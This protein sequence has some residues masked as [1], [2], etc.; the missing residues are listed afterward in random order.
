MSS[1]NAPASQQ[2]AGPDQ[3]D[4]PSRSDPAMRRNSS[5]ASSQPQRRNS[6][7][8]KTGS[9]RPRSM[10][11]VGGFGLSRNNSLLGRSSISSNAASSRRGSGEIGVALPQSF[12]EY[13]AAS[14]RLPTPFNP[15]KLNSLQLAAFDGDVNKIRSL[16]LEKKRDLD[17][18]D[19][20]HKVTALHI[21]AE[22][23]DLQVCKTLITGI[24]MG[25]GEIKRASLDARNKDGRTALILAAIF[26]KSDIV[27]L[28]V[29]DQT[30]VDIMD[31]IGCG[32]LHYALLNDDRISFK[33]LCQAGAN[34]RIMD[35]TKNT[36]LHHAVRLGNEELAKYMLEAGADVNS[37]NADLRT[38][39]HLAAQSGNAGMVQLLLQHNADLTVPD[40]MGLKP[41]DL[42]DPDIYQPMDIST[43]EKPRKDE[44]KP[45]AEKKEKEARDEEAVPSKMAETP[46]LAQETR[47]ASKHAPD[48]VQSEL[49]ESL[50]LDTELLDAL[51]D[52]DSP[53]ISDF[54]DDKIFEESESSL[55]PRVKTETEPE[56]LETADRA[57]LESIDIP[58]KQ[59]ALPMASKAQRQ[60]LPAMSV[61]IDAPDSPT[62]K[63]AHKLDPGEMT[64]TANRLLVDLKMIEQKYA[65]QDEI[66]SVVSVLVN[67]VRETNEI[68][69][70]ADEDS[71]NYRLLWKTV[72]SEMD[73]LPP[74]PFADEGASPDK[75]EVVAFVQKLRKRRNTD[76]TMAG[77]PTS[78]MVMNLRKSSAGPQSPRQR[79]ETKHAQ[80][81]YEVKA[82]EEWMENA[83]QPLPDEDITTPE[84]PEQAAERKVLEQET[85]GLEAKRSA[86]LTEFAALKGQ[87]SHISGKPIEGDANALARS[88]AAEQMINLQLTEELDALKADHE[89]LA[90]SKSTLEKRLDRLQD[91]FVKFNEELTGLL[92]MESRLDDGLTQDDVADLALETLEGDDLRHEALKVREMS[93]RLK[94]DCDILRT[95][96][97]VTETAYA[98]LEFKAQEMSVPI[99]AGTESQETESQRNAIV[100]LQTKVKQLQADNER[101]IE[102]LASQRESLNTEV[103][104]AYLQLTESER[105][106][107][108]REDEYMRQQEQNAAD[109]RLLSEQL[110]AAME[111]SWLEQ[112]E[113]ERVVTE[114][115]GVQSSLE[116]VQEDLKRANEKI[117]EQSEAADLQGQ[118]L[119]AGV[120]QIERLNSE[121]QQATAK[122]DKETKLREQ[123][124]HEL[125]ELKSAL[126]AV[127]SQLVV[128]QTRQQHDATL[129]QKLSEQDTTLEQ[130]RAETSAELERLTGEVET[131]R[132]KLN[133]ETQLRQQSADALEKLK[134]EY[135]IACS[136]LKAAQ[137]REQHSAEEHA[138]LLAAKEQE[139][140]KALS[141]LE[142]KL[143]E[144]TRQ[145]QLAIDALDKLEF[146]FQNAQTSA[147]EA[148]YRETEQYAEE[149]GA[150]EEQLLQVREESQAELHRVKNELQ[151][152]IEK[153]E[154]ETR[155]RQ[156]SAETLEQLRVEHAKV[157]NELTEA[158]SRVKRQ[159]DISSELTQKLNDLTV[160]FNESS[161]TLEEHATAR[162]E[163]FSEQTKLL[164]Q[165]E[166]MKSERNH[167]QAEL[168]NATSQLKHM[169]SQMAETAQE[170]DKLAARC[171]HLE[172]SLETLN[173][174]VEAKR[175]TIDSL[176]NETAELRNTLQALTAKSQEEGTASASVVQYYDTEMR[177]LAAQIATE[178]ELRVARDEEHVRISQTV[179]ELEASLAQAASEHTAWTLAA[180]DAEAAL[181][182]RL[183]H[184]TDLLGG[185]ETDV[186][187]RSKVIDALERE[188]AEL[189]ATLE[190]AKAA[191]IKANTELQNQSAEY[192]ETIKNLEAGKL[193]AL[194]ALEQER[195][196]L[197]QTVTALTDQTAKHQQAID[198]LGEEKLHLLK[199]LEQERVSLGDSA[200]QLQEQVSSLQQAAHMS[201]EERARQI[202]ALERER[203]AQLKEISALREQV[204]KHQQTSQELAAAKSALEEERQAQ[205]QLITSLKEQS[206]KHAKQVQEAEEQK[207]KAHDTLKALEAERYRQQQT[208][209]NLK[210]ETEKRETTIHELEQA[211]ETSQSK[212]KQLEKKHT[213]LQAAYDELRGEHG[214]RTTDAGQLQIRL[215]EA[216]SKRDKAETDLAAAAD[217]I[218]GL[219]TKIER[220]DARAVKTGEEIKEHLARIDSLEKEIAVKHAAY[221]KADA[222]LQAAQSTAEK[223]TE[224]L[225]V[226]KARC[227]K[228][229]MELREARA[230]LTIFETRANAAETEIKQLEQA[231]LA[232]ERMEADLESG[233]LTQKEVEKR[234]QVAENALNHSRAQLQTVSREKA[235]LEDEVAK[236]QEEVPK[237]RGRVEAAEAKVSKS[238]AEAETYKLRLHEIT[239]EKT[240]LET[241]LTST[242]A[243]A[244]ELELKI[245][246]REN[247]RKVLDVNLSQLTAQVQA[248]QANT[249]KLHEVALAAEGKAHTL[250]LETGR[251]QN[252]LQNSIVEKDKLELSCKALR[253]S[254]TQAQLQIGSLR[255]ES[256][257]MSAL[258]EN[259]ILE[260]ERMSNEIQRLN[261]ERIALEQKL[262]TVLAKQ[263]DLQAQHRQAVTEKTATRADLDELR[264]AY[265]QLQEKVQAAE[266]EIEM[267]KKDQKRLSAILEAA[268]DENREQAEQ[269]ATLQ[270]GAARL[271][272]ALESARVESGESRGALETKLY[273][274]ERAVDAMQRER[275]ILKEE[276]DRLKS[277]LEMRITESQNDNAKRTIVGLEIQSL[278]DQIAE[279]QSKLEAREVEIADMQGKLKDRTAALST[280][281]KE[282]E[283]EIEALSTTMH[284]QAAQNATLLQA[285]QTESEETLRRLRD[286]ITDVNTKLSSR[287]AEIRELGEKLAELEREKRQFLH[288]TGEITRQLEAA[289]ERAQG[290]NSA[291]QSAEQVA[292]ERRQRIETLAME[293]SRR[294][295]EIHEL[296]QT[297]ETQKQDHAAETCELRSQLATVTRTRE[298]LSTRV[299]E[300][301]EN[302]EKAQMALTE[303]THSSN[304]DR[305]ELERQ[306][307]VAR[308]TASSSEIDCARMTEELRLLR[309]ALEKAHT[310]LGQLTSSEIQ[311][312]LDKQEL[313]EH[314][315]RKDALVKQVQANFD[316]NRE[317]L[318]AS[319]VQVV[320]LE[321]ETRRLTLELQSLRMIK[322]KWDAERQN[323]EHEFQLS[324]DSAAAKT[325]EL[326]KL[327]RAHKQLVQKMQAMETALFETTGNGSDGEM[328]QVA[329]SSRR[330]SS[331]SLTPTTQS[332]MPDVTMFRSV[333]QL[334]HQLTLTRE[335]LAALQHD[336]DAER[337]A[338][339]E[340]DTHAET[341]RCA[342]QE[343]L[344]A[345]CAQR[346]DLLAQLSSAEKHNI[347][348]EKRHAQ[349]H[350]NDS[351]ALRAQIRDARSALL[352]SATQ[353]SALQGEK[354]ELMNRM[355]E[356]QTALTNKQDLAAAPRVLALE[357]ENAKLKSTVA[358]LKAEIQRMEIDVRRS[359]DAKVRKIV[360]TLDEHNKERYLVEKGW[361]RNQ[362]RLKDGYERQIRA[363]S[364]EL[365]GLK[366]TAIGKSADGGVGAAAEAA[367][368]AQSRSFQ[369]TRAARSSP[370]PSPQP[371]PTT[372][373]GK[374][375][376]NASSSPPPRVDSQYYTYDRHP[377]HHAHTQHRTRERQADWE[378]GVKPLLLAAPLRTSS[379]QQQDTNNAAAAAQAPPP[380]VLMQTHLE[381]LNRHNRD[382]EQKLEGVYALIGDRERGRREAWQDAEETAAW[383]RGS[384]TAAATGVGPSF[385][386]QERD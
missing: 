42:L 91:K 175:I 218:Q 297:L 56:V 267:R 319:E 115:A 48:L 286:Q 161:A 291:A 317:L 62:F 300:A 354:T 195:G 193:Q 342:L 32:A 188:K 239:L 100:E 284:E 68:A 208:L 24:R 74:K 164:T 60:T 39:L 52:D 104:D 347:E 43:P 212:L 13:D 177:L 141:E 71:Q 139:R 223:L 103:Q 335:K 247:E 166:G 292:S 31:S 156:E 47:A 312:A 69:L 282:R 345:V 225:T 4:Q 108:A 364:G 95:K 165:L 238:A 206:T 274:L 296:S 26:M 213:A 49:S 118:Q 367:A 377:T 33:A 106:Y 298:A 183:R 109:Q 163:L 337:T 101:L 11:F 327:Q 259:D 246:D 92:S 340:S 339:R 113:R 228:Y 107:K 280:R 376:S 121:I 7:I 181:N 83:K 102:D 132:Q 257:R 28:L 313:Q 87:A 59:P 281:I 204:L 35:K 254:Q 44:A 46:G 150:M 343:E 82:L 336:L 159:S 120:Q 356:L 58:D 201:Q 151:Q 55:A 154:R 249:Q 51:D 350:D 174:E 53:S 306:L 122:L 210:A 273:D 233:R 310:Q 19:T 112:S 25:N 307:A 93:K 243:R 168:D 322:T 271:E 264:E 219:R 221:V 75:K 135:D 372:S 279:L 384:G 338:R 127:N 45:N 123:Y 144:E 160:K 242:S 197:L 202:T 190:E 15:K 117:A 29:T 73:E 332:T 265:S 346:D 16:M 215:K 37:G 262:A 302:L 315:S 18:L 162:A 385:G 130:I 97:R 366:R 226:A 348:F 373:D 277:V 386:R 229:D 316:H 355:N 283:S 20:V 236:L 326:E 70:A 248:S 360:S 382:I 323:M 94:S 369:T 299:S 98:E 331:L 365:A 12:L 270:L 78:P 57:S 379:H 84:S 63:K 96:L 341:I 285:K 23:G 227:S 295:L 142:F 171:T 352:A 359:Y 314:L 358:K 288:T 232:K 5:A 252:Q 105:L 114:L 153:L 65:G 380:W 303:L 363:L 217:E 86:L 182:E 234:A 211:V 158:E 131:S 196:A 173:A 361:M 38:P 137:L 17:K 128:S 200:A 250:E 256:G 30:Q 189:T 136:D 220:M 258:R 207:V 90:S 287:E 194:Q 124:A 294:K 311:S 241:S 50:D 199:I 185:L 328:R 89:H 333:A 126:D 378:L 330:L 10:S 176:T 27:R 272:R 198:T 224:D 180:K 184:M 116:S 375:R 320:T 155:Q 276:A 290:A 129:T 147:R 324:A 334:Q 357:Q 222:G 214:E 245:R 263:T 14:V 305:G 231:R 88:L 64:A 111:S 235:V 143:D 370:P 22:K 216:N 275:D 186:E 167:A 368:P 289:K 148:Q 61:R 261:D 67:Y 230:S 146:D 40:N 253:E 6:V 99:V 187:Q 309:A 237:L 383:R 80:L 9:E 381:A 179:A 21:A 293:L 110:E 169:T 66:S 269:I 244:L 1:N 308:Q 192:Q 266:Q 191:V 152:A 3:L 351:S 260:N 362:D 301:Q 138:R 268:K 2:S 255:E 353:M 85:A 172:A 72:R 329:S 325:L 157:Q 251:L 209:Q 318:T 149:L 321:A 133:E 77:S 41:I 349:L 203:D 125:E 240:N 278:R 304:R 76:V 79:A 178:K 371:A 134:R 205:F 36:L 8:S 34:L 119:A 344:A 54:D 81:S 145:R 140:N 374:D 170:R